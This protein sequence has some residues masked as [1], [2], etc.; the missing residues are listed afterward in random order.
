MI[1]I[2]DAKGRYKG[3]CPECHNFLLFDDEDI[4]KETTEIFIDGRYYV[5][6][7]IC[8]KKLIIFNN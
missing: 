3:I 8:N 6:C 4:I 2:I 5:L 7:P 1:N